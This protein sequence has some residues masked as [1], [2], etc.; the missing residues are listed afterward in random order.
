[1]AVFRF[2]PYPA[3]HGTRSCKDKRGFRSV[4]M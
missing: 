4:I 3:P 1:M 2:S